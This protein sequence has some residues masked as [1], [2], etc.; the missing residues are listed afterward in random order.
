MRHTHILPAALLIC[1]FSVAQTPF[2][3]QEF[4]AGPAGGASSGVYGVDWKGKMFFDAS[5]TAHGVELWS[6]DE[7]VPAS[8]IADIR[9]GIQPGVSGEKIIYKNRLFFWAT[10]GGNLGTIFEYDGINP[11]APAPGC[12]GVSLTATSF[13]VAGSKLYFRGNDTLG[14]GTKSLVL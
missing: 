7:K 6:Y 1:H 3:V 10:T 13:T 5:D 4:I 12:S 14:G 2:Q 9:V 8:M 11:P